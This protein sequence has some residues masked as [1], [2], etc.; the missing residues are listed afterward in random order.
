MLS[1]LL[2]F[3]GD[4]AVILEVLGEPYGGKV[5]PAQLLNDYISIE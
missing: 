5:T 4:V 1:A 3:H 2:N